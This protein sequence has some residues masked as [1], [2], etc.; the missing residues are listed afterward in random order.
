[1]PLKFQATVVA[2]S[3]LIASPALA[4]KSIVGT[5][6]NSKVEC[7]SDPV[8]IKPLGID[9]DYTICYFNAVKRSGNKIRWTGHC[10]VDSGRRPETG[11]D[12][13]VDAVLKK[14]RLSIDGLGFGMNDLL[15][16]R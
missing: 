7:K 6:A 13:I 11:S 5:W 4:E 12:G 1:M 2:F 15:R 14:D 10:F 9:S 16:C 3:V 8:K